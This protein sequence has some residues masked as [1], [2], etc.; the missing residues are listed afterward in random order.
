MGELGLS[1]EAIMLYSNMNNKKLQG[2]HNANSDETFWR[3][4][5]QVGGS[6]N[7]YEG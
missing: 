7:S 6:E 2:R 5:L 4:D 3:N 1:G